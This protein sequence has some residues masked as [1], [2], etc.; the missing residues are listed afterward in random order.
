MKQNNLPR[1]SVTFGAII[2]ACCKNGDEKSAERLFKEMLRSK[3]YK[4]RIPPFNTMIQLYTQGVK[5]PDREKVLYYFDQMLKQKIPP[6]DHSEFKF[7][8]CISTVL[9]DVVSS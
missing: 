1:N 5:Q 6:S 7:C 8:L 2:N 3:Y 9:A 4:P